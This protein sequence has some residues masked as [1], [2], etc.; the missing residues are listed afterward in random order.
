MNHKLKYIYTAHYSY[1]GNNRVDITVKGNDP[2]WSPFKPTWEMVMGVK[3]GT[4]TYDEYANK[5]LTI[6]ANVPINTWN[7]LFAMEEVVFVCFCSQKAFCH[8][9][10]LTNY[11]CN[12]LGERVAYIGWK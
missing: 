12:L 9:N 1:S 8:R 10:I 4:M 6:L 5:Y 3:N 7:K 11:I 2:I